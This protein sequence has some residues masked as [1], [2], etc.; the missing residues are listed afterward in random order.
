M[1]AVAIDAAEERL[2]AGDE[3]GRISMW[4]AFGPAVSAAAEPPVAEAAV[5]AAATHASGVSKREQKRR[6]REHRDG[7]MARQTMHWHAG[8]VRSLVFS[9]DSAYL[10][11]G[12]NEA[13]LVRHLNA[14]ISRSF[15]D[16]VCPSL[17]RSM[18]S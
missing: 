6:K 8:P 12:G 4:N 14:F 18:A 17:M 1:Q 2:A 10:L 13:V 11:S 9:P 7:G 5:Q 3:T 16:E 15:L